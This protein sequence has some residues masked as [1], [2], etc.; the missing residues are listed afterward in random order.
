MKLTT[1]KLV[2]RAKEIERQQ[3]ISRLFGTRVISNWHEFSPLTNYLTRFIL[4][5][6]VLVARLTP[7]DSEP[8]PVILPALNT[9]SLL[10]LLSFND[11]TKYPGLQNF[12]SALKIAHTEPLPNALSPAQPTSESS[13]S[14][15]AAH[16]PFSPSSNSPSSPYSPSSV[17]SLK[18]DLQP[19]GSSGQF[20]S[21]RAL[22]GP[23][24][25]EEAKRA[26]EEWLKPCDPDW[27]QIRL[28]DAEKG[29][30]RLGSYFYLVYLS[31][32]FCLRFLSSK[33]KTTWTE[34]WSFLDDFADL[35][36]DYGLSALNA[37]LA[38]FYLNDDHQQVRP[39]V[40][41]SSM[42][43]NRALFEDYNLTTTQASLG[44]E[45]DV[46][47]APL[48]TSSTPIK[49]SIPI[50]PPQPDGHDGNPSIPNDRWTVYREDCNPI[51]V[52]ADSLEG[53]SSSSILRESC[54]SDCSL[55]VTKD[56]ANFAP[57]NRLSPVISLLNDFV[58]ATP[59]RWVF[60]GFHAKEK[61]PSEASCGGPPVLNDASKRISVPPKRKSKQNES[62]TEQA[63]RPQT[64]LSAKPVIF[65]RTPGRLW[66]NRSHIS[67]P[68]PSEKLTSRTALVP[69]ELNV[70]L[71]LINEGRTVT[72][73]GSGPTDEEVDVTHTKYPFVFKWKT[74]LNKLVYF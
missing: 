46:T 52:L 39:A 73:Q 19:F 12:C 8:H 13:S 10:K 47:V 37:Y 63:F 14:S 4:S 23:L 67:I 9:R 6:V 20:C 42:S 53:S 22:L 31:I 40:A 51:H 66:S 60:S 41:G 57:S 3:E 7:E 50:T 18:N 28:L 21:L 35:R 11:L 33:L 72:G 59:L 74:D 44:Q 26:T 68:M 29:Y 16:L 32:F 5:Y 69:G 54:A 34:Y 64:P 36:T 2:R 58:V 61:V 48:P 49:R 27:S 38:P 25:Y 24:S 17:T 15:T 62:L 45:Q 70:R 1:V 55:S 65:R 71:A 30:E 56:T 43:L